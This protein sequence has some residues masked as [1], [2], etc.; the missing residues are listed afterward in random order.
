MS[1]T[2]FISNSE[3]QAWKRCR[4][5]WWLTYYRKLKPLFT[6]LAGKAASGTRV[7]ETLAHWYSPDRPDDINLLEILHSY[8]E[9]DFEI[10]Y[11]E[12]LE[13]QI[14]VDSDL[15]RSRT[16]EFESTVSYE[17]AMIAG[18]TQWLEETGIDA[19]LE[20]VSAETA[21]VAPFTTMTIDGKSIDIVLIGIVDAVVRRILDG[22]L[23]FIDHK[24]TA[25]LTQPLQTL[26]MNEQILHYIYLVS[27]Q[28]IS[29]SAK[30]VTSAL[31]NLIKRVKRTGKATPP[32][33]N[34]VQ[35]NHSMVELT[36]Y[37][38][39]LYGIV[40][41]ILTVTHNLDR[42]GSHQFQAYPSVRPECTWD[43]PFFSICHMFDDGSHVEDLISA[44][45]V[46]SDPLE[47][48]GI[49]LG[50]IGGESND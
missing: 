31:W 36:A 14:P 25:S 6:D 12:M 16:A 35:V 26:H 2:Y 49:T 32:F 41:D 34:R 4:R 42:G 9:R 21:M 44:K 47:R 19:E 38:S 46:V 29:K 15:Y 48:Y 17:R 22:K 3:A 28:D 37:V 18:Y 7:H 39:H 23:L 24:T 20:I 30:D 33:Y 5:K 40:R 10:I 13:A 11:R 43:C 50:K 27:S 8:I 45:Y 1:E